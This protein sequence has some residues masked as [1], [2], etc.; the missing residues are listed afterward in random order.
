[1]GLLPDWQIEREIK[2]EPFAERGR[3]VPEVISKAM[4]SY[5][6]RRQRQAPGPNG[7][8]PPSIIDSNH[9]NCT[10]LENRFIHR[11]CP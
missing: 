7:F 4:T 1:M 3:C 10:F 2:I 5:G 11:A 6:L 8:A 9:K